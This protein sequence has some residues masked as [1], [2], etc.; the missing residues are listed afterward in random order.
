M[1]LTT[2]GIPILKKYLNTK[3]EY[4]E[5]SLIIFKYFSQIYLAHIA[6][7]IRHSNSNSSKKKEKARAW[8]KIE[9][10]CESKRNRSFSNK[11]YIT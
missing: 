2:S 4:D 5:M 11:V 9:V 3:Y 10:G 1:Y 7:H 6:T 8:I